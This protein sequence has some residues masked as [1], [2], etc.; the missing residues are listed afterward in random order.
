M[1]GYLNTIIYK[2]L[3]M[4]EFEYLIYY[5]LDVQFLKVNITYKVIKM[6]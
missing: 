3:F 1:Y 5:L 6:L 2:L 4:T